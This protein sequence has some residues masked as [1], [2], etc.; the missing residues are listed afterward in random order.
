[1]E[2]NPK[3][4]VVSN[5]DMYK[6]DSAEILK[7]ELMK[8]DEKK[9]D[10][11]FTDKSRYHSIPVALALPRRSTFWIYKI[12]SYVYH[13][14]F[15]WEKYE[16]L[17]KN[18]KN[19]KYNIN[20]KQIYTSDLVES[21]LYKSIIKYTL[22]AAFAIFSSNYIDGVDRR[23]FDETFINADEDTHLSIQLSRN[24][25]KSKVIHYLIGDYIGSTLG[26]RSQSRWS[27][28][29]ANEIYIDY[30]YQNYKHR[31]QKS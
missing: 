1:M 22:T 6:I 20:F 10:V 3:W 16:L 23:L 25:N 27:R 29:I 19:K 31:K 11:I 24:S 12:L 28:D 9:Y 2:Y 13:K 5:D 30:I 8:L 21:I 17:K 4:V 14:I 15:G 18:L 26:R 7:E